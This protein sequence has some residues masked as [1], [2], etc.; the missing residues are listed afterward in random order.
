MVSLSRKLTDYGRDDQAVDGANL[1]EGDDYGVAV[2]FDEEEEGSQDFAI[3]DSDAESEDDG[4]EAFT[5][6]V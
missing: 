5:G 1:T 2:V 3:G 4:V 6:A